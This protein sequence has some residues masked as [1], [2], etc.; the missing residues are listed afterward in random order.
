MKIPRL[1]TSVE[2]LAARL[3]GLS[4]PAVLATVVV[5]EGSTY[6]KAG[7]RML[8]EASGRMTGLL[9]GGCLERD[10]AEHARAVLDTGVPAIA[11][12]DMRS[13]DDLV[14]GIGAGCEGAMRVLL[15]RVSPPGGVYAAL[16]SVVARS[17]A[18]HAAA[19]AV[20]HE[21]TPE[22]LGTHCEG[23]ADDPLTAVLAECLERRCSVHATLADGRRLW[24]EY[25][26]PPPRV[27]VCGGG[28]DAVPLVQLLSGLGFQV[29][30][31]DHRPV[32]LD[33][34]DWQ[35]AHRSLGPAAT[36]AARVPLGQFD[37]AV[38]MSHHLD[39]DAA[40]LG[41]L[42]LSEVPRVG[43]LGPRARRERLLA[44]VGPAAA[45]LRDRLRGPVG[46]DLGAVTPEGIA[47]A[48]AAELHALFAGRSAT[49]APLGVVSD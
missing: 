47:L 43:L 49:M 6:R 19:I 9:S 30:V 24:V 44:M 41:A 29:T 8:I 2:L 39:S 1:D 14:F 26:A 38:V 33:G 15:E 13:A 25:L 27:L 28:P 31:T 17:A 46:L 10:L 23:G 3:R 22:T 21:G 37:G 18:G 4:E 20:V 45:A 16:L 12:Y 11:Q 35:G 42:A 48:I 5:T 40:Y 36:L 32:Y 34:G 7:A